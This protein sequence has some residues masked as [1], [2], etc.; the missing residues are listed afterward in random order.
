MDLGFTTPSDTSE[1]KNAGGLIHGD[2]TGDFLINLFGAGREDQM[3]IAVR[4][5]LTVFF[6]VLT[7]YCKALSARALV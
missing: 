4:G 7:Y 6:A 1:N 5:R 2:C 3:Q